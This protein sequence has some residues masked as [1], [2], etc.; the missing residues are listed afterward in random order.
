[1]IIIFWNFIHRPERHLTRSRERYHIDFLIPLIINTCMSQVAFKSFSDA[2]ILIMPMKYFSF[3]RRKNIRSGLCVHLFATR[4]KYS[5]FCSFIFGFLWPCFWVCT[6]SGLHRPHWRVLKSESVM[7]CLACF[8]HNFSM[9]PVLFKRVT[10]DEIYWVVYESGMFVLGLSFCL[11]ALKVHSTVF[12]WRSS[13]RF[14]IREYSLKHYLARN[15]HEIDINRL[16]LC[17]WN[18]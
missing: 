4:E 3:R 14:A 7:R 11:H 9:T 18:D 17:R 5:I 12:Y 8:T 6:L 16:Q 10:Y 13:R 15:H 1:M 2:K